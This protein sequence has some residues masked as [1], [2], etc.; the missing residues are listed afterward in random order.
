M[1]AKQATMGN[2]PQLQLGRR[3][4]GSIRLSAK[5][6]R[7]K[8][9]TAPRSSCG[10]ISNCGARAKKPLVLHSNEAKTMSRIPDECQVDL[11]LAAGLFKPM[12]LCSS[13][14]NSTLFGPIGTRKRRKL[15]MEGKCS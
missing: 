12:N 7:Q 11:G 2:I 4:H 9:K 13:F 15:E 3:M 6:A 1:T 8:D 5:I 14:G 10:Q